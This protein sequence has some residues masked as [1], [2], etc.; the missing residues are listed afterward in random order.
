MSARRYV[1]C[2]IEA[3]GLDED[4]DIIEIALITFQDE[5]VFDVYETLINPLKPIP[6]FIS[7][8]TAITNRSL[9][10]A[11]KFYEVAD[12]IRMR[13]DG[14]VFVSHNTEFDLGLLKKKYG[15]MGQELKVKNFCTL[16]V[17]QHEIP[18]LTNYNLDA[19]CSFFNI[20]I[21]DRHRAIGDARATLELFKELLQLRFK[22]YTKIL[23][24]PHHEKILKKIPAKAGILYFKDQSGKVIRFESSF[25]MEKTARELLI[26]KAENRDLLVSANSI[27]HEITGSALIAEFKKLLFKP[28]LPHWMIVVQD[29]N[30]EKVFRVRPFKKN[31]PG[32]WYFKEYS[33]AKIK[34]KSLNFEL[35]DQKYAYRE[36]GKSKEEVL[37]HNHKVDTLSKEA[38]FPSEH[39]I[40]LGEGRSLGEKSLIVIRNNHVL[41]YGYTEASEEEIY[42]S[43]ESYLTRRFFQHLGADL[44]ARKYLRVLKNLRHK[45]EGWRSLS[46]PC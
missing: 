34:L 39:L 21:I 20:K 43:P 10:E 8:L 16:K 46:D 7:S 25:N 1:I 35:K 4:C 6:E 28:Y 33:D 3:T 26:A 23:Y 13:L 12:A 44:S 18:G 31:L 19:L 36:G 29:Q 2:D 5:K 11:P 14:S 30:G 9:K 17:A 24:L 45:T 27:D 15:E 38:R 42:A 37:R 41:G 40:I 22:T 32:L